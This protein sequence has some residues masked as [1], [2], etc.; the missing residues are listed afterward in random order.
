[1]AFDLKIANIARD[2]Q[3]VQYA[4]EVA[5]EIVDA[6]PEGKRPEHDLL[7]KRLRELR[8]EKVNWSAIS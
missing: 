8:K 3:L 1:M 5:R 4:R 2:G 6:D 7:W